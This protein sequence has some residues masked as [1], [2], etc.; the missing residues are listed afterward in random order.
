MGF[1]RHGLACEYTAVERLGR[2]PYLAPVFM[3]GSAED[4]R[5]FRPHER[6]GG[7]II[8]LD[9]LGSPSQIHCELRR[10]HK[11]DGA[12]KALGPTGNRPERRPL[13]VECANARARV[14]AARGPS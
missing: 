4:T 3:A 2:L 13:P 9:T 8:D 1:P 12:L 10:H 7:V 11:F 14:A 5:M 6:Q